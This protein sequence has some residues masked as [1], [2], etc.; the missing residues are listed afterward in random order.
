MCETPRLNECG[1]RSE[2]IVTES[3]PVGEAKEDQEGAEE[4]GDR[5][6]ITTLGMNDRNVTMD[7]RWGERFARILFVLK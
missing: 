1:S 5:D 3:V 4:I 6:C 7:R 2:K